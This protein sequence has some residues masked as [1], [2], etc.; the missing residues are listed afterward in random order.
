MAP[1]ESIFDYVSNSPFKPCVVCEKMILRSEVTSYN[2]K[3]H[4]KC[5]AAFTKHRKFESNQLIWARKAW[6]ILV[7]KMKA[8]G[9]H[10]PYSI[11]DPKTG[12]WWPS[13][14]LM[15][16]IHIG[17]KRRE[18]KE[19]SLRQIQAR[20]DFLKNNPDYIPSKYRKAADRLAKREVNKALAKAEYQ[21]QPLEGPRTGPFGST[22]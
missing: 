11:K 8:A 17:M 12:K 2:Q 4:K 18:R 14:S 6:P 9:Y 22:S 1:K 15:S 20:K 13:S 3:T 19:I 10:P 7:K 16:P 21:S 5:R